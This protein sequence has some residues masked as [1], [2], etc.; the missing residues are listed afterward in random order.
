MPLPRAQEQMPVSRY[1]QPQAGDAQ[2]RSA[3]AVRAEAAYLRALMPRG[4]A[5]ILGQR[6]RSQSEL[7]G[8]NERPGS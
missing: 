7:G 2:R 3:R 6:G 5:A 1:T 4:S 8:N